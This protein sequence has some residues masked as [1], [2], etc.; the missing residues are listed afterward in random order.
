MNF[1]AKICKFDAMS[2]SEMIDE[3]AAM[4]EEKRT[5]TLKEILARLYPG[6]QKTVDRM[7][8]RMEIPISR[9]MSGAALR[10]PKTGG[11]SIWKRRFLKNPRG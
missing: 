9:K 3:L 4:P 5:R 11:W 8:R 6:G 1:L 2:A 7:L 10:K